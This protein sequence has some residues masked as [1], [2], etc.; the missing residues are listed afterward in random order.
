M[1][2]LLL[3]FTMSFF[4]SPLF[5]VNTVEREA[6]VDAYEQLYIKRA[7]IIRYLRNKLPIDKMN[8]FHDLFVNDIIEYK[9][10]ICRHS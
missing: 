10:L 6:Q 3:S 9:Y 4:F 8:G 2:K 7:Q 5:S 1:K